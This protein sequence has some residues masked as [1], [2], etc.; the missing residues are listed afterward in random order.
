MKKMKNSKTSERLQKTIQHFIGLEEYE[1]LEDF[2]KDFFAE[3]DKIP[4][5]YREKAVVSKIVEDGYDG[6]EV[7][8]EIY[9]SRPETDEEYTERLM[10]YEISKQMKEQKEK[11]TLKRLKEKYEGGKS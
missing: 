1:P 11:E 9:Y 10:E 7:Q 5:E 2:L 4:Q 3:L 6:H 8:I